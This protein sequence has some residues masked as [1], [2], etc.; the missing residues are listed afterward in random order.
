M[1]CVVPVELI[2]RVVDSRAF[3]DGVNETKTLQVVPGLT[4][5]PG[6]QVVPELNPKSAA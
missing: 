3:V 6:E 5:C 4:I 2:V 1:T